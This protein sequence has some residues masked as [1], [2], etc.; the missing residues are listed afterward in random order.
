MFYSINNSMVK[1]RHLIPKLD[2]IINELCE[3]MF[4]KIDLKLVIIK[5]R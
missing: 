2:D 5:L 3:S 4:S 1:Y